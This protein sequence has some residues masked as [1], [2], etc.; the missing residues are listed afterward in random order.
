MVYGHDWS[1]ITLI[2]NHLGNTLHFR[3]EFFS[4]Q[5]SRVSFSIEIAQSQLI[6]LF[7]F[8]VHCIT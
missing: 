6:C 5:L 8:G 2:S 1:F 4:R 3:K 7:R